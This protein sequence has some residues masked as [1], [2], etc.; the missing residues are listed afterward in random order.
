MQTSKVYI[1]RNKEDMW[2]IGVVLPLNGE[3]TYINKHEASTWQEAGDWVKKNYV[4]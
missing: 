4:A 1:H 3:A 2:E